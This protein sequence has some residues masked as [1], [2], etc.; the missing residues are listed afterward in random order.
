MQRILLLIAIALT[1]VAI[2]SLFLIEV[3]NL[4][5][6]ATQLAV[7][8]TLLIPLP[9]AYAL[10]PEIDKWNESRKKKQIVVMTEHPGNG[11]KDYTSRSELPYD[12]MISRAS[13]TVEMS[14]LTFTIITLSKVAN[15][16]TSLSKGIHITFLLININTSNTQTVSEF[17]HASDDIKDQIQKSLGQLCKLKAKYKDQIT[18]RLC[19]AVPQYSITIIDRNDSK[20][21]WIRVEYQ[22]QGRDSDSRP[23]EAVY[24][25]FDEGFFRQYLEEYDTLLKNS[26]PY[27]CGST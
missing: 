27:E 20:R 23:T 16:E 1:I 25:I 2:I 21:A 10:K 4:N 18:I 24:K 12:E 8:L 3:I 9:L 5:E 6:F 11:I 7:G 26:E 14:A 15:L 17:F 19:D 13:Q 22:I